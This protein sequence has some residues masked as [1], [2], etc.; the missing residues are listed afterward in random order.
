MFVQQETRTELEYTLIRIEGLISLVVDVEHQRVTMRTL[1]NVSAKQIAEAI[2]DNNPNMEAKLVTRNKYNQEF[3]V[4]LVSLAFSYSFWAMD[5]RESVLFFECFPD[6][7]LISL[8][9]PVSVSLF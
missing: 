5:Y 8:V 1:S 6:I 2:E 4:N 9:K 7:F 3:L